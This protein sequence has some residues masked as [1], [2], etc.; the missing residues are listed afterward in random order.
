MSL[1]IAVIIISIYIY[2][3]YKQKI[4]EWIINMLKHS[5]K[6]FNSL[7]E[8]KVLIAGIAVL[9]IIFSALVIGIIQDYIANELWRI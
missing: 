4:Q 3:K 7:G 6:I 5:L 2:R 9:F 8:I 1:I